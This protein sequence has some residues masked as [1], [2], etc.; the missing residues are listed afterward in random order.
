VEVVTKEEEEAEAKE[1]V[2]AEVE[3]YNIISKYPNLTNNSNSNNLMECPNQA[4]PILNNRC[5]R[6]WPDLLSQ[7]NSHP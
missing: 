5:L 7:D 3:T 2:W 6:T 1:V 4:I